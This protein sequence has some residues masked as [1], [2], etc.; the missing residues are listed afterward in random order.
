MSNLDPKH[1]L[2]R[3]AATREKADQTMSEDQKTKLLR[4]AAEYER[5]AW[6]AERAMT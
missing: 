5:M 4:V 6:R 3:A 2:D 1:W